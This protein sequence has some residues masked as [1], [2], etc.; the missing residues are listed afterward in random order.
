[1]HTYFAWQDK[2]S[3]PLHSAINK[4]ALNNDKG[5]AKAFKDWL[6]ELFGS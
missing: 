3:M 5:T 2:P 6:I 4:I 1:M